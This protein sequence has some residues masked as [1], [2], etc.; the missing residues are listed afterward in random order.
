MVINSDD[1]MSRFFSKVYLW[2]FV[3]LLISGGV[4]YYTSITPSMIKFV[5]S[6]YAWILILELVVV[7]LF[8]ALR[9]KVSPTV[10][11]LLFVLYSAISGLTL[12][13]IFLVYKIQSVGI[14]FLSSALMFAL[15]AVYGYITRQDLSS[16]G[17]ILFFAL[18][19]IIIMSIVN[20]FVGNGTLGIIISIVSIAVF[21]GLT[22]WDMQTLKSMYNYYSNDENELNKIAIYG[23]LDLYLDFINIFLQLL[24]L[25]G[26]SKD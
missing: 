3:G 8:S 9:K 17:K 19:A 16:F 21:L 18:L 12:S 11:K 1:G 20:I 14:V 7:I 4:A 13:S 6:G 25:F 24:N 2:M 10:A 26:N 15:L 23:A 22:A 5:Y